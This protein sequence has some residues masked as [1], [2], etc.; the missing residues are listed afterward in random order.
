L[1]SPDVGFN[2]DGSANVEEQDWKDDDVCTAKKKLDFDM[3]G[4]VVVSVEKK[5]EKHHNRRGDSSETSS[6]GPGIGETQALLRMTDFL[7]DNKTASRKVLVKED[8]TTN[9]NDNDS[10]NEESGTPKSP[11]L[12]ATTDDDETVLFNKKKT[13][14]NDD[15]GTI[16]QQLHE[17]EEILVG[18]TRKEAWWATCKFCNQFPCMW[19][20]NAEAVVENDKVL[21]D[22]AVQHLPP[23][24]LV[25]RQRAF[26]YIATLVWGKQGYAYRFDLDT[27]V[28]EGVRKQWPAANGKYKGDGV[29]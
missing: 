11:N 25:R 16:T 14:P 15:E 20:Q 1:F 8:S 18:G 4:K 7:D 9:N 13:M 2:S 23:P 26:L 29:E 10:T 22:I 6:L 28:V 19:T 24:N 17:Q 3:I 5:S 27:C 12:L 21:N